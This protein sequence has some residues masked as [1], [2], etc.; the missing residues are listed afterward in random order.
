MRGRVHNGK[1]L[2]DHQHHGKQKERGFIIIHDT[3]QSFTFDLDQN[4]PPGPEASR[5][6]YSAHSKPSSA[7]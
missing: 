6:A 5:Q 1:S 7:K 2:E 3:S 4:K